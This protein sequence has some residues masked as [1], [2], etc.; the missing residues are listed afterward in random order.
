MTKSTGEGGGL[1]GGR[2]AM[3]FRLTAKR[4]YGNEY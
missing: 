3:P 1:G 4:K 2:G